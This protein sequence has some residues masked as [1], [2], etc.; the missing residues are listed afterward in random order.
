VEVRGTTVALSGFPFERR[1][2]RGRFPELLGRCAW[3][4]ARAAVRLLCIHQCVEGATVGPG[5][6]TFTSGADVIRGRDIAADFAAVLSGHIHRQQVLTTD[7]TGRLL[8]APVLYPGSLERVST[9]EIGEPKGFMV[10]HIGAGE[11]GVRWEFRPLPARPMI[12]HE[13]CVDG[14]S[15]GALD[16]AVLAAIA[17]APRDAVLRIRLTGDLSGVDLTLVSASRLR[18]RA[19]ASMNVEIRAGA[20]FSRMRQAA[21]R[22]RTVAP[23]GT[24]SDDPNLELGI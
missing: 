3:Q 14:L 9:A 2:V 19:P 22:R 16:A 13:V 1:D 11:G 12:V 24:P 21:P 10:V 17:A 7:L 15:A 4:R 5:N 20:G 8:A 18:G 6:F 23:A